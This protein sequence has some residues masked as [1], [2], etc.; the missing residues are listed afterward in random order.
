MISYG[1]VIRSSEGDFI[2]AK[3]DILPGRFDA[4]EAEAIGVREALSWLKKF[5]LL[6][7]VLE[8]DSLQVFNALHDNVVY[9]HGFGTIIA[10]CKALAQS[11]GEV[12]F[13]FVRR[14]ANTTAHTVAQVRDSM[15]SPG[16]WRHV[17]P[18]WLFATL[19]N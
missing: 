10:Y 12:A 4:R 6:P 8:M 16:E 1:A 2:A 5:S 13:S 9:P 15:S 11:L 17:P 18:P 3:S 19:S 14:S 7:I